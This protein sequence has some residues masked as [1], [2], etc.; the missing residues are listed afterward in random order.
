M[1]ESILSS[2]KDQIPGTAKQNRYHLA[3]TISLLWVTLVTLY[4]LWEAWSYSGLF[5][6]ISEWEY[7]RL[8]RAYPSLNTILLILIFSLPALVLIYPRKRKK[9]AEQQ[10]DHA[11]GPVGPES[12]FALRLVHIVRRGIQLLFGAACIAAV[13]SLILGLT[14][15][16]SGTADRTIAVGSPDSQ[17]PASGPAQ[18]TGTTIPSQAVTMI[19]RFV[20]DDR[21]MRF[22]PIVAPGQPEG[23]ARYFVQ[24]HDTGDASAFATATS[25][26]F[27]G[28]LVRNGLP[29]PIASLYRSIGQSVP[30]PHYVLYTSA[31]AARWPY[32]AAAGQFAFC[33]LLLLGVLMLQRRRLKKQLREAE[34]PAT[35]G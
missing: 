17:A 10:E 31:S 5:A 16:F 18:L 26:S 3:W 23:T 21:P 25:P 22:V 32:F 12:S 2:D 27:T 24:F 7:A 1:G 4:F 6:R 29:G 11:I 20:S 8:N 30:R 13:L 9:G 14:I 28:V 34:G 15:P 33:A 35:A 19:N